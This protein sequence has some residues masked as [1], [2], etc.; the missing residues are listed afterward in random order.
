MDVKTQLAE[1][2]CAVSSRSV[3]CSRAKEGVKSCV[4]W[5]RLAEMPRDG[6][7]QAPIPLAPF[8]VQVMAIS[9]RSF[10]A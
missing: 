2:L 4:A 1:A 9:G 6:M 5:R 3:A 8:F 7:T 10:L